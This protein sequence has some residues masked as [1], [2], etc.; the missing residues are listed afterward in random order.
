M[1]WR[2]FLAHLVNVLGK[3]FEIFVLKLNHNRLF[4]IKATSNVNFSFD[5]QFFESHQS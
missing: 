1:V 4:H 5:S 3:F 2:I